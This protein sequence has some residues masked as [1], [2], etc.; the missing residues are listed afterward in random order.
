VRT[1]LLNDVARDLER[2]SETVDQLRLLRLFI[3]DGRWP[4]RC[5]GS[6]KGGLPRWEPPGEEM[7]HALA[8]RSARG[9]G[10]GTPVSPSRAPRPCIE[11][12]CPA[13]ADRG[14][15]CLEHL[16]QRDTVRRVARRAKGEI[17][18][19]A[20]WLR[21]RAA[22]LSSEPLCQ[23]SDPQCGHHQGRECW[24]PGY[25]VDH[26]TP[27]ERGGDAWAEENLQTL[28]LSCHSRKTM[29]ENR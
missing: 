8:M 14:S 6:E 13:A 19:T 11:P 7:Y 20:R 21:L 26:I 10:R 17:Y 28:C 25:A 1:T 3:N 12:G 2:A 9:T 22:H 24:R 18:K 27:I 5:D 4:R 16:R 15:R 23:C 29:L